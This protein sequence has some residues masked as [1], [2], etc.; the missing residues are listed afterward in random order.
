MHFIVV[1][2]VYHHYSE[3][4]VH[5]LNRL[6]HTTAFFPETPFYENCSY[7]RKKFYKLGYRTLKTKWEEDWQERVIRFAREQASKDTVFLCLTG[8][9]I[10]DVVLDA[11]HGAP[12]V[13]WMWDSIRRY[14]ASFQKRLKRYTHVFAFEHDDIAYAKEKFS[15]DMKYLPLG[16]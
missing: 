16:Y 3:S 10:A 5:T 4:V 14:D 6:G 2:P 12:L 7:L 1:G 13:L 8:G 9:M 15:L 11:W